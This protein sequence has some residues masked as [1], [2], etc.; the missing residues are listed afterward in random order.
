MKRIILL[1][2]LTT[3]TIWAIG[4][5]AT[6]ADNDLNGDGVIV[7]EEFEK[8]QA[9][10]MKAKADEG[11]MMRNAANAPKFSD[12]DANSDGKVTSEEFSA[13]QQKRMSERRGRGMGGGQ[14]RGMM[15]P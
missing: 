2:V 13:F 15:N 3:A 10:R 5:R 11:R 4:P 1:S 9:E 7:Q 12:F 6:F 14:G 8:A